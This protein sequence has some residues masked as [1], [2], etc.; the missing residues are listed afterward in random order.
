MEEYSN[1]EIFFISLSSIIDI[2]CIKRFDCGHQFIN[3]FLEKEALE[4]NSKNIART[5]LLY[6]NTK[7][8]LIG[9]FTLST[10]VIQFINTNNKVTGAEPPEKSSED[11]KFKFP[12]I[13]LSYLGI[14][15]KYQNQR[16][17]TLLIN[18]IFT[19]TGII[20]SH[21]AY[22]HVAVDALFTCTDF[23]EKLGFKYWKFSP[24]N[25]ECY[26]DKFPMII[27][28]ISVVDAISLETYAAIDI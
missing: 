16:F 11:R 10:G 14:D 28:Y 27:D 3:D 15:K 18:E 2:D 17:G 20:G 1:D 12:V 8:E 22:T 25:V 19:K 6:N 23:Y 21:I 26:V 24:E 5:T 9:F 13:D 4:V 7:K